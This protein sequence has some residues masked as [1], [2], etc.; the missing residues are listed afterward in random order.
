M[1]RRGTESLIN[2]GIKMKHNYPHP[3]L[4]SKAG[5]LLSVILLIWLLWRQDWKQMHTYFNQL[6]VIHLGLA[7]FLIIGSQ[8]INAMRWTILLRSLKLP[9]SWKDSFRLS[10]SGLFASNFLPTTVGGDV[11]RMMGSAA[12]VS[13]KTQA[14]ASIVVDRLANVCSMACLLPFSISLLSTASSFTIAAPISSK[15]FLPEKWIQ[16]LKSILSELR[17]ALLLWEKKPGYL[18][19]AFVFSLCSALSYLLAILTVAKGLGM[20]VTLVKVAGVLGITYFITLLPISINGYGVREIGFVALYTFIGATQS[21]ALG[22]A[23]LTRV[24]LIVSSLPGS[25]WLGNIL[26]SMQHAALIKKQ[27]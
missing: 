5:S 22:L 26:S 20:E 10:F 3:G 24:L 17:N 11:I 8:L 4:L 16:R 6:G 27:L 12:L 7:M 1:R 2:P 14:I 13:N 23:L 15:S 25:F 18:V 21:Q 9:I 19:L